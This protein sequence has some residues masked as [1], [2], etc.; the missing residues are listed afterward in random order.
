M[1]GGDRG[2]GVDLTRQLDEIEHR[3]FVV[4]PSIGRCRTTERDPRRPGASSVMRAFRTQRLRGA[5]ERARVCAVVQ[6]PQRRQPRC[7]SD[8]ARTAG[9]AVAAE[10]LARRHLAITVH[11]GDTAHQFH[12]DD[13]YCYLARPRRHLGCS[14]IWAIDD[15]ASDNGA[16]EVIQGSHRWG[17][18]FPRTKTLASRPSRWPQVQ[19]SSSSAPCGIAVARTGATEPVSR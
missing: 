5:P 15:F 17:D 19:R 10:L 8:G 6:S 9:S 14:V 18:E 16:T 4:I 3:G 13:T 11:P 1:Q 7:A 12:H 2:D